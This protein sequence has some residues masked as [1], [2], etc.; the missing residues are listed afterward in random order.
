MKGIARS[1]QEMKRLG[2]IVNRQQ[3]FSCVALM[4]E[5]LRALQPGQ[6]SAIGR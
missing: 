4:P 1:F 5:Q 6:V 2:L 3:L